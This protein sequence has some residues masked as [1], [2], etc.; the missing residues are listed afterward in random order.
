MAVAEA[1]A[2]RP[3]HEFDEANQLWP[4]GERPAA[5]REAA[6]VFRGRF[7]EQG[8]VQSVQSVDLVAAG[9]PTAYAFGGA[10]KGL[11]PFVNIV[12]RLVIV[13]FEDFEGQSRVLAWEPTVPE[14]SQEAPF[15]EQLLERYG[16]WLSNNIFATYY[17]DIEQALAKCGLTPADVDYVA[18]DHLHVQDPRMMLGTDTQ[19]AFYPNAKM[20]AQHKEVDTFKSLHPTQWAWYVDG[21]MDGIPDERLILFDG[22][23]EIGR[24]LAFLWTPGHTDGNMSLCVNTP[25]GIWVSSENGVAADNWHPHLSKIPGVRKWAQFFNRDVVMNSNTLEDSLDQYDS[26]V[27]EHAVADPSPRDPRWKQVLPSS[28]LARFKRQWPVVPTH[29]FGGISYR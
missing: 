10:A 1:L 16:E 18:F 3:F 12:N 15:Y 9:Y 26:M 8:T 4:R 2:I 21:G 14:G 22:D 13:R 5:I 29:F 19:P 7:K 20:L 27:K 23:V 6:E 28:E 24:G 25:D 11:N 17:N